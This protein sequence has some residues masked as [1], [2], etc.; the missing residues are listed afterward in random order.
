MLALVAPEPGRLVVEQVPEPA[1]SQGHVLVRARVS[2]V[3]PGTELRMLHRGSAGS[4]QDPGW[5]AIG[6]FGYLA[7]GDVVEVGPGVNGIDVGDRV[8]CGRRWGAH[9]ELL[10]VEAPA[11]VRLPP[12]IDYLDGACAYWAVPPLS[13]IIAAA[14]R[15]YDDAAVI[16]LGPLGLAAVQMLAGFCRRVAAIDLV[17]ERCALAEEF[18]GVPITGTREDV[19]AA[20]RGL[21]PKGPDVVVQVAGTQPA[22]EL[23]LAIVRPQGTVVN[24]G[25]LPPLSNFDLFRPMQISGARVVPIARPAAVADGT[26]L[27]TALR[28]EHLPQVL[29]M[30]SRRRLSV[31]RLCTWVVPIET[32]PD[33]MSLLYRFPDQALGLAFAWSDSEVVGADTFATAFHTAITQRA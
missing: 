30:I 25:V 19:T 11:V 5:P 24:V 12:D 9:R 27:G 33:A 20:L 8:A 10:D 23:A 7:A 26:D 22:L 3:S 14:P 17:A 21:M 15:Y 2:A 31:R 32:A 13:G 1:V 29:D 4:A 28:R 6:A 18:G 16:G